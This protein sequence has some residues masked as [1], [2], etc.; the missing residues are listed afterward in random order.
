MLPAVIEESPDAFV[1][2]FRSYATRA[3]LFARP[4]G[5]PLLEADVAGTIVQLLERTNPYDAPPGAAT[6]IL[7]PTAHDLHDAGPDAVAA[8]QVP[9]R[10]AL[11]GAGAVLAQA[12]G[13]LVVDAGVPVVLAVEEADAWPVGRHVA[14]DAAPPIHA[15]VLPPDRR[16]DRPDEGGSVDEAH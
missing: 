11:R 7:N 2:R 8:L 16:P 10:G 15:F 9:E 6:L 4:E 1:D 5:S 12:P 13:A 3:T 14:F